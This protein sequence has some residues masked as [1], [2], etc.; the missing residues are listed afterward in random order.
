MTTP[1]QKQKHVIGLAKHGKEKAMKHKMKTNKNM[2]KKKV[3]KGKKKKMKKGMRKYYCPFARLKADIDG[4]SL[5][6]STR[7]KQQPS[8]RLAP[9]MPPVIKESGEMAGKSKG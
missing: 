7:P 1:D 3:M 6:R 9:S 8:A 4:A 2:L 5:A